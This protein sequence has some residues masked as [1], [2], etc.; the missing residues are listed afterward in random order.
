MGVNGSVMSLDCRLGCE[1]G[2]LLG[3]VLMGCQ[4]S[5]PSEMFPRF[6]V[7]VKVKYQE[8]MEESL[9]RGADKKKAKREES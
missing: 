8:T 3:E 9:I 1:L 7:I 2:Q 6:R 5:H 4:G